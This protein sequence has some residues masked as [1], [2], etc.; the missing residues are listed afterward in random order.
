M[1]DY[2]T[3]YTAPPD[4]PST[5]WDD[6]HRKLGNLPPVEKA[7]PPP[8]RAPAPDAPRGAALLDGAA[9]DVSDLEDEF[10]DDA[11]LEEYRAARL[12]ELRAA[13]AR[14][15]S[16]AVDTIA[17]ADYL[18][19]VTHA[20]RGGRW[21]VCH[22]F[23]D[24]V[25]ACADVD[26]ALGEVARS[27]RAAGSAAAAP[28]PALCIV[29]APADD[30]TPGYPDAGL[31]TLLVYHDGACVASIKG[32]AAVAAPGGG[33]PSPASVLAALTGAAPAGLRDVLGIKG[34]RKGEGSD[35]E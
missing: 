27:A 33:R 4:A 13:A 31:P 8:A 25:G 26:A 6:H 1:G 16:A 19:R 15:E 11:F 17:K 34:G 2:H 12:A 32:V 7:A 35:S 18:P 24:G 21:V 20:S 10:G 28:A 9:S 5:Q 3:T 29:R 22:L 30:I 14:A 23:R